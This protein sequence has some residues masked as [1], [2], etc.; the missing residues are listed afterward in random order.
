MRHLCLNIAFVLSW[1][2]LAGGSFR[3]QSPDFESGAPVGMVH[4]L[5]G[6]G[7]NG[8]NQSPALRWEHA[9]EGTR[10]FVLTCYDP[11]APTGSG[12]WHWVVYDL[13]AGTRQLLRGAGDGS[14]LPPGAHQGRTDFGAPGYGGPCPPQGDPP[15]RY[16]FTLWALK[17]DRLPVERD[18]SPAMIGFLTRAN[19]LG[20]AELQVVFGR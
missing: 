4:V 16:L 10:S 3:L 7:C 19:A 6:F 18:A 13:P 8:G 1:P 11:D 12:W 2:A 5:N 15:H 20:K 14:A 9:P 17:I